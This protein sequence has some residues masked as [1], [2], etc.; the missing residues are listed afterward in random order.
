[1]SKRL[2]LRLGLDN[3][4]NFLWISLCRSAISKSSSRLRVVG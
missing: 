3:L 1:L 2:L 4:S